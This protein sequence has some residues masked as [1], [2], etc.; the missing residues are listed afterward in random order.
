MKRTTTQL[1]IEA[2][3]DRMNPTTFFPTTVAELADAITTASSNQQADV[4]DLGERSF[5]LTEALDQLA[6]DEGHSLTIQNGTIERS[7]NAGDFRILSIATGANV[8]LKN[9]TLRG[10][11]INANGAGILNAGSLTIED[12][13]IS[14]NNAGS[15]NGGG[16][17]NDASGTIVLISGSTISGNDAR[18]GGGIHNAGKLT[19]LTH[20]TLSTNDGEQGG[21]LH[22]LGTVT[23]IV[24][25]TL[26]G[27][28]ANFGGGILNAATI[29]TLA[30]STIAKGSA[31]QTGG[32]IDSSGTI[33]LLSSTIIADNTAGGAG[34]DLRVDTLTTAKDNLIENTTGHGIVDG[35]NGNL[36][37]R[38]PRLAALANNGG[39]TLTHAWLSG[40][41]VI[42][43]GN[44]DQNLTSDQRGYDSRSVNGADIGAFEGGA[45][46]P[47]TPDAG[48][49]VDLFAVGID[50]GAGGSAD[51]RFKV[52]NGD[53]TLRY[54]LQAYEQQFRGGVRVATG[55]VNGDGVDDVI[56]GA[57]VGGGP[58]VRVFDGV[59][60]NA[61]S[62][63]L[64]SF[65]AFDE[66]SRTGIF[67][68]AGDV[69]NDDHA[70]IIVSQ[71]AGGTAEVRI[72]SGASG[73]L[74]SKFEVDSSGFS[75][76][77]R[78]TAGNVTGD[79]RAE[80]IIVPGAGTAVEAR[81]FEGV[82][83]RLLEN[84]VVF[85]AAFQGGG[86]LTTGDLNGD[87]FSE[88]LVATA[89]RGQ[90]KINVFD[91]KE[92]KLIR[93]FDPFQGGGADGARVATV[94]VDG[95]GRD[96]ILTSK[97]ASTAPEVKILD[98]T[99]LT[100]LD[101]LFAFDPP[102]NSQVR[103]DFIG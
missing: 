3:E 21:G 78:V 34:S 92:K 59:T 95:D 33:T 6:K 43:A 17:Y 75:G 11:H 85:D 8:T 69:N 86:M 101:T 57:G 39:P 70:D 48:D 89:S 15:A 40:S 71:D 91:M 58:R 35:N 73:G 94:D 29:S 72:F 45:L 62:G 81:V 53:G 2:L 16:I 23:T 84:V 80:V 100:E 83:G 25:T 10:G 50:P 49:F 47:A 5:A 24:N 13:V 14:G 27:N 30:N 18:A 22:N 67:V 79:S 28:N 38:D 37:G 88:L 9:V 44:N 19:K 103:G 20:S 51:P 54:D 60:G 97:A 68:A 65:F 55:D 26:S 76:G 41:P 1:S 82:S 42:D 102:T 56:T 96:E 46:A 87:G 31:T 74:L 64:G 12:S 52:Y 7:N 66:T 61:V 36:V 32:G 63:V 90:T 93:T 99:T 4:I 77:I 98:G